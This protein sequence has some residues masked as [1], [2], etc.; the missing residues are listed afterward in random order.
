MRRY[1]SLFFLLGVIIV[2]IQFSMRKQ[3]RTETSGTAMVTPLND[4]KPASLLPVETNVLNSQKVAP[5]SPSLNSDSIEGEEFP[6]GGKKMHENIEDAKSEFKMGNYE[7][8]KALA[9]EALQSSSCCKNNWMYGNVLHEAHTILGRI[10]LTSNDINAAKHHL[11]EAA[12]GP[13]SPQLNSF[14]PNMSLAKLLLE[15]EEPEVVLEYVDLCSQFWKD[16]SAREES[17]KWKSL[18]GEGKIPDF[19]GHL[20]YGLGF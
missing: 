2:G 6:P 11:L 3:K 15:K 12:K 7:R 8:S 19:G 17:A 18:I 20:V 9:L 10:A 1:L 4:Q 16:K 14:G 5:A 13:G